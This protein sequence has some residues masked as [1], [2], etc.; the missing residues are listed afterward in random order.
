MQEKRKFERFDLKIETLLNIQDG[1]EIEKEI[2]LFSKDISSAGAFLEIENSLAQGTKV[3]LNFL[4]YQSEL[5]SGTKDKPISILTSGTVVRTNDE[6]MAV[7]F[8]KLY[9]IN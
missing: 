9:K 1:A 5:D 7:E 2:K 3:S 8:D 6:G 4:I